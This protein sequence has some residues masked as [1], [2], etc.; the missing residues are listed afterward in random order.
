MS[1]SAKKREENPPH[2]PPNRGPIFV[3]HHITASYITET[4]SSFFQTNNNTN[5]NKREKIY[6]C[7]KFC[8]Y[9]SLNKY[10]TIPH[11]SLS[12]LALF[13]HYIQLLRQHRF[14]NTNNNNK[15]NRISIRNR[16]CIALCIEPNVLCVPFSFFRQFF[17][18]HGRTILRADQMG[19]FF[20][21]TIPFILIK[22]AF[23]LS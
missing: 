4:G 23:L 20:L 22:F 16:T 9:A 17:F 3:F 12:A 10:A 15:S 18:S 1:Q 11:Q 7:F 8:R 21:K 5:N 19:I 13:Q 6:F 14:D 2:I